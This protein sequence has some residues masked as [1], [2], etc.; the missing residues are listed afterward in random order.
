[1]S[2]TPRIATPKHRINDYTVVIPDGAEDGVSEGDEF[3]VE[4]SG[5]TVTATAI[6]VGRREA[7]LEL[8][9]TDVESYV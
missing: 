7:V 5:D 3:V 9:R 1:M 8:N 4:V 2:T 6:D